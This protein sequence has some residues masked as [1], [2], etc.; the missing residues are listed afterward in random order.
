MN[1]IGD[2]PM[3]AGT[4]KII[5]LRCHFLQVKHLIFRHQKIQVLK[6]FSLS[7]VYVCTMHKYLSKN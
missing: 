7:M 2:M 5:T 6:K 4:P 1:S 3:L